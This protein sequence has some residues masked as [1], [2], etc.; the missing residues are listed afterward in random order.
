MW[1]T[2]KIHRDAQEHDSV[3]VQARAPQESPIHLRRRQEHLPVQHLKLAQATIRP[4][5]RLYAT[6]PAKPERMTMR[7]DVVFRVFDLSSRVVHAATSI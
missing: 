4:I 2:Q 3:C 5:S 7:I 1:L 6:L